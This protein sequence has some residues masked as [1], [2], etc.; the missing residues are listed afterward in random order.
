MRHNNMLKLTGL[1]LTVSLMAAGCGKEPEEADNTRTESHVREREEKEDKGEVSEEKPEETENT[2]EGSAEEGTEE[3]GTK[4]E[5]TAP[6]AELSMQSVD[7]NG[8]Y[9]VRVGDKVYFRNISLQGLEEGAIFGEFLGTENEPVSCPLLAYDL[10]SNE[11]EKIGDIEGTGPLYAC[12][13]GF[14]IGYCRPGQFYDYNVQLYDISTGNQEEYCKGIPCGVSESGNILVVEDYSGQVTMT[15]MIKEGKEIAAFGG[16]N[17]FYQYCGFAGE[18]LIMLLRDAD[19]RY[20]VCSADE[21]GNITEL[22]T[23][24]EEAYGYPEIKQFFNVGDKIYISIGYFEGTGHFLSSWMAVEAECG[25]AG[26]LATVKTFE[27]VDYM[28][29]GEGEVPKLY[30]DEGGVLCDARN[31][32]YE[33]FMGSGDEENNLYYL[34]DIFDREMLAEDFIDND[35]EDNCQIIQD[36]T[37]TY[38][39]VF[40]IYADAE[41]DSDYDIGW[42]TGYKLTG[43]H[44]CAIPG[45][46]HTH[47]GGSNGQIIHIKDE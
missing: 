24:D 2:K 10:N 4:E 18:N 45:F 46:D 44:I 21:N 25:K 26:S 38:D 43:W 9:F 22:G 5:T 30:I 14:Y 34:T 40:I 6:E 47:M 27:D 33:V 16:E 20:T 37:A 35:Y 3:E 32:P 36:I 42:R 11:W 41:M 15:R 31:L 28:T 1:I 13:E 17:M 8:S 19:E 29:Y 12:P 7:N 39:T 23:L